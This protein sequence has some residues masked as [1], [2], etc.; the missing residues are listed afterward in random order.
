MTLSC[1]VFSLLNSPDGHVGV[2]ITSRACA[3]WAKILGPLIVID[4]R[5]RKRKQAASLKEMKHSVS[6]HFPFSGLDFRRILEA[7]AAG[8]FREPQRRV[9]IPERCGTIRAPAFL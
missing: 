8:L 2:G 1:F 9:Q 3:L 6:A 7:L 5:P 4:A